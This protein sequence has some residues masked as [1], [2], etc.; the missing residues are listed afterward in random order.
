MILIKEINDLRRELNQAHTQVHDLEAALGIHRKNKTHA[1]AA[2]SAL[3]TTTSTSQNTTAMQL[4]L[5]EKS[6]IIELQKNEIV[7]LRTELMDMDRVSGGS[8]ASRP[9]SAARLPPMPVAAQ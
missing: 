4:E 7:R 3:S 6:K 8:A 9:S 2:A 1:R 5:E